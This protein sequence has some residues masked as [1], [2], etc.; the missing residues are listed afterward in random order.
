MTSH[1]HLRLTWVV[2]VSVFLNLPVYTCVHCAV[3]S[4]LGHGQIN[5]LCFA[6]RHLFGFF[7]IRDSF[8]QQFYHYAVIGHECGN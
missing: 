1:Q 5:V 3:D 2:C 8:G 7:V 4:W 6:L